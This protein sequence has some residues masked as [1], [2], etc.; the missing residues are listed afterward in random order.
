[1]ER[2][3]DLKLIVTFLK[4][5]WALLSITII[6]STVLTVFFTE[7]FIKPIYEVSTDILVVQTKDE[8]SQATTQSTQ[9]FISTYSVIIKSTKVIGKVKENLNLDDS[10][11]AMRSRVKVENQN[12]S[13]IITVKVKDS[14]PQEAEK[15]ATEIVFVLQEEI[16]NIMDEKNITVLSPA[17]YRDSLIPVNVNKK[18]SIS[19]G[20]II[21]VAVGILLSILVAVLNTTIKSEE[22]I[23]TLTDIPVIGTIQ[24]EK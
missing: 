21:G 18:L 3:V 8:M 13:Q 1:M 12:N 5:Y 15:I 4:K 24:K 20:L 9:Q 23:L 6:S 16:K 11:A 14:T 10:V 2:T 22:D 17:K 19:I 7:Y